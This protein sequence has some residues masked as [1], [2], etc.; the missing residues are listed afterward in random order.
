MRSWAAVAGWAC[1]AVCLASCSAAFSHG[2][3]SAACADM[4]PKHIQ[5]QPQN[6]RTHHVAIH[7]SRSFYSPGDEVPVTVRSSR[8][9]M[10]FLL[11]ARRVSNHEVAGTFVFL[12]SGSMR[13]TCFKESDSVTH[14]DKSLKRN[15]SF[16]WKAPAQ[17]VGDIRFLLSVVQSYFVYWTRIESSLVSQW[18]RGRAPPDGGVEPG[19][20][21]PIP[22]QEPDDS[23]GA[24]PA[25]RAP[26]T[27]LQQHTDV[28]AVG[29]PIAAGEDNLEPVPA[30]IWATQF[31]RGAE[32]GPQPSHTATAGSNGQQPG[33]DGSPT[34][35]PSRD[36][37]GLQRLAALRGLSAG[38]LASSASTHS[39]TRDQPSFGSPETCSPSDRDEQD[40]TGAS[41]RTM[42]RPP[43][44]TV[45]SGPR[46]LWSSE[47]P[48]EN[49]AGVATPTPAFH[50][51]AAS[52][53][54]AAGQAAASKSSAS[55]LPQSKLKEPRAGEGNEEGSVGH[56][57][58]TDPRPAVGQE[59]ASAPSGIQLGVL[60]CLSATLGMA[61][62]ASLCHLHARYCH[63]QMEMSF[64][65]TARGPVARSDGGETVRVRKMGE[66]SFVLVQAEYNWIAPSMGS[67][68]T[69]L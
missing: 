3:S 51:P 46:R 37:Q 49:G 20:R 39:R 28:L 24:A 34:L 43:P 63:R 53:L 4:S 41:N 16:V 32:T 5:A 1:T 55:F 33:G 47:A 42:M 62:A 23:E 60:L 11:Q 18:T 2:A 27:L 48:T 56:P 19:S 64:D 40:K 52:R 14:S 30:G 57:R 9:F 66:N 25:P 68:K 13:M 35:E 61:L 22:G 36:V 26:A 65:E 50:T 58:K 17:P 29:L 69:V 31:P 6:P 8:D 45:L 15:L 12:P 44:Y 38:G 10:G 21:V 7:T 67:K 54:P 59:G